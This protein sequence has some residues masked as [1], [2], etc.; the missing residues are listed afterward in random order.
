LRVP[1][2][3]KEQNAYLVALTVDGPADIYVDQTNLFPA[4]TVGGGL[5][6]Q[7]VSQIKDL[8]T[9]W[10][11]WPGGNY[12]SSYRWKEGVGPLTERTSRA[13]PTWIGLN[14]HYFGMDEYMKFSKL[15]DLEP[16]IT[17]NAGT[18]SPEEAAQW[19]EYANGAEDTPMGQL[20]AENGHPQPYGVK[21]WNIGN[22]LWGF[23]Q[24]GYTTPAEYVERYRDFTEAMHRQ[25]T[26]L[27]F[28]SIGVGP[29]SIGTRQWSDMLV[30]QVDR[31]HD[32]I[33]FHTYVGV[34]GYLD[35]NDREALHALIKIPVAFEQGLMAFHDYASQQGRQDL[36]VIVGEYNNSTNGRMPD[37]WEEVGDLLTY[38][39]WLHGFIRQGEY[40]IGA[41]ATEYSVF[42]PRKGEFGGLHPRYELFRTYNRHAGDQPVRAKLETPVR[43][44]P[45]SGGKDVTPI[46]NLPVIDGVVLR[47]SAKGTLSIGLINRDLENEQSVHVELKDFV[48]QAKATRHL[49]WDEGAISSSENRNGNTRV[50]RQTIDVGQMFE[51]TLPPHSVSLINISPE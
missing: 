10:V 3:R 23:W 42:N 36:E 21:Y 48:P 35:L 22:E 19:V 8:E 46:F 16:L 11:R 44:S 15:A 45:V 38:A 12:A 18:G 34:P 24:A 6:P 4:D 51:V 43:Q 17:V 39:G 2:V 14:S 50:T 32:I 5:D 41:N 27:E 26:T 47:D 33:D 13:N 9:E 30:E 1:K 31:H 49:I 40:V 20:R 37:Q 7:S 28:I 29:F 25:D